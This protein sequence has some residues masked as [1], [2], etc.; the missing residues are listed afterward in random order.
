MQN[1]INVKNYIQNGIFVRILY[2]LIGAIGFVTVCTY[3][4]EEFYIKKGKEPYYLSKRIYRNKDLKN[5]E[6][7]EN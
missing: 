5:P 3:I 4:D 7:Y 1:F 6:K 2:L